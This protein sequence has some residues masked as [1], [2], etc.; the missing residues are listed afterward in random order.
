M[1]EDFEKEFP[2]PDGVYWNEGDK[3]YS[4]SPFAF[5]DESFIRFSGAW[6]AWQA[7]TALQDERVRELE[8]DAARYQWLKAHIGERP[9]SLSGRNEFSEHKTEYVFPTLISWVDFCGPITLD[10]AIDFKIEQALS[11]TAREVGE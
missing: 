2:I 9:T 10:E 4:V 1:N 11:A 5:R 7:A 6:Q 8:A 3:D